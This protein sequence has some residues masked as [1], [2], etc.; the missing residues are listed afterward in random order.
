[1]AKAD[2][3]KKQIEDAIV[4]KN[5]AEQEIQDTRAELES[6]RDTID[7]GISEADNS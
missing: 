2:E 7:T 5:Q 1:M 6:L 4:R 3:L